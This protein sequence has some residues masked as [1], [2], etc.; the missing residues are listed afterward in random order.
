MSLEYEPSSEPLHIS[1]V[2]SL[3]NV[4]HP[5][6]IVSPIPRNSSGR[7]CETQCPEKAVEHSAARQ[8]F[9]VEHSVVKQN[10]RQRCAHRC[11]ANLGQITQSRPWR[12]PFSVKKSW[13]PFKL[14][15]P[16]SPEDVTS[17]RLSSFPLIVHPPTFD[18]FAHSRVCG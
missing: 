9:A 18:R 2:H 13:T 1:A 3:S 14:F 4:R 6:L 7:T 17:T 15:P 8:F 5:P 11:R 10:A 12:E 16:R